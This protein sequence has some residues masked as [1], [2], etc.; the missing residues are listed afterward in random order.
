MGWKNSTPAFTTATKTIADLANHS[1]KT[2]A[3]A[4]PHALYTRAAAL[5]DCMQTPRAAALGNCMR[6]LSDLPSRM[7]S[8]AP[9]PSITPKLE[10]VA[11]IDVYVDDFIAV[12]QGDHQNLRDVRATVLH[13]IDA[14]FRPNDGHDPNTLAEPVS[15]KKLVKGDA[16]WSTH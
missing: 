5:D 16:S 15:L 3:A 7:P 6:T 14:V 1:L 4:Q 8:V 9:D 13:S 11:E 12:A 10:P 2:G